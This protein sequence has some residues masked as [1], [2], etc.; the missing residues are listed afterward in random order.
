MGIQRIVKEKHCTGTGRMQCVYEN[1][2]SCV[3]NCVFLIN[4]IHARP[5]ISGYILH[6]SH[7]LGKSPLNIHKI[8]IIDERNTERNSVKWKAFFGI[9][10]AG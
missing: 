7:L 1:L 9:S 10:I 4:A 8:V 2:R 3:W 6:F 5:S